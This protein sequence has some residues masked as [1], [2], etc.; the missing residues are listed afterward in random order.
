MREPPP[1]AHFIGA[2]FR[3]RR[4][5]ESD[6]FRDAF[7]ISVHREIIT[8]G[9]GVSFFLFLS[10]FTEGL[11][12]TLIQDFPGLFFTCSRFADKPIEKNVIK[13]FSAVS[14][15]KLLFNFEFSP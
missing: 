1:N 3:I 15:F 4:I 12:R 6:F 2:S 10:P 8:E 5:F 14:L 7:E 13:I 9:T 11:L